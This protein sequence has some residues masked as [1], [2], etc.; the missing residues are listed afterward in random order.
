MPLF[1][2]FTLQYLLCYK[3][4][5]KHFSFAASRVLKLVSRGHWRDVDGARELLFLLVVVAFSYSCCSLSMQACTV[6][7]GV[8]VDIQC[9][10]SEHAVSWQLCSPCLGPVTTLPW[11][12]QCRHCLAPGLMPTKYLAP[13]VHLLSALACLYPRGLFPAAIDQVY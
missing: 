3:W 5:L 11:F 8:F 1:S 9:G 6:W 2:K 10:T 7:V 12:C 4:T 13:S